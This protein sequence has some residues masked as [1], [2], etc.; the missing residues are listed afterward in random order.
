MTFDRFLPS[1]F[2]VR[3]VLCLILVPLSSGLAVA[4]AGDARLRPVEGLLEDGQ[5]EE[6]LRVLAGLD[7]AARQSAEG[8]LLRSTGRIMLGDAAAGYRD[9]EEALA[10]DPSLR[11][12]WLN[13][14]GLEIAEG[15]FDAAYADLEKA[16]ELDPE[17]DD[18][19]LNLGAVRV[20]QGRL[21]EA[22]EHFKRYLAASPNS[23]EAF[24][25]VAS[26]YAISG[27]EAGAIEHLRR[28]IELDE[29][30]R[31]R[32]RSDER[33]LALQSSEYHRLLITDSYVPPPDH[34]TAAAAFQSSYRRG[35][36]QLVY[37]VL[38]A[39]QEHGLGYDPQVEATEDWALIWGDLR[40]KIY[41]QANGNGVVRLS[42]PA[43]RFT[44]DTWRTRTQMLFRTVHESLARGE[45]QRM[46]LPPS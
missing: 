45:R 8:L 35:D 40:I 20:M 27:H 34:H 4:S 38:D 19:H 12:A 16:R 7:K 6:A 43:D 44:P 39:L 2:V 13:L 1:S 32:A 22:G 14:A 41:N 31:L 15:R 29:R 25:L 26:N 24:Y 30:I 5:A 33:F 10:L 9:L 28:A 42:A 18:N 11:Q 21:E 46:R 23:P 3:L 37:A 17:A 36:P